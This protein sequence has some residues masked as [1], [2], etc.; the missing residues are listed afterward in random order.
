MQI[1]PNI[2]PI[3]LPPRNA[4]C[5]NSSSDGRRAG[6]APGNPTDYVDANRVRSAPEFCGRS[7]PG[8]K[9]WPTGTSRFRDVPFGFAL[10]PRNLGHSPPDSI[11]PSPASKPGEARVAEEKTRLRGIPREEPS[12]RDRGG[13]TTGGTGRVERAAGDGKARWRGWR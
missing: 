7:S 3:F 6:K 12:V 11:P 13:G 4:P 9:F 2:V 8:R 1:S 10:G 5:R